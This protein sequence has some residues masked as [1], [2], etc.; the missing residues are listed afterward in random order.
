MQL[1]NIKKA[2]TS[3]L[4]L[5]Q[6]IIPLFDDGKISKTELI[7]LLFIAPKIPGVVEDTRKALPAFKKLTPAGAVEVSEHV[8]QKFDIANDELE[9]R[10]ELG[11]DLLTIC[12]QI[13]V[14]LCTFS[15][16]VGANV[17]TFKAD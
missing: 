2:F 10:I 4:E 13:G 3:V 6:D 12:Y 5:S 15:K 16:D 7:G 8:K 9:A 11:L 17:N 14:D 1:E